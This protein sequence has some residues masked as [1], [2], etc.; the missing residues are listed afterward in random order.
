MIGYGHLRCIQSSLVARDNFAQKNEVFTFSIFSCTFLLSTL[1]D[2]DFGRM[3]RTGHFCTM[4][5]DHPD[6]KGHSKLQCQGSS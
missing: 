5:M 3:N 1:T 6:Q 2:T 4:L